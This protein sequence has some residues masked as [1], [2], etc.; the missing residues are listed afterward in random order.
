MKRLIL[1]I[2]TLSVFSI[3]IYSQSDY[4]S[5][6]KYAYRA[7]NYLMD[8][9]YDSAAVEYKKAFEQ[10]DYIFVKDLINTTYLSLILKNDSMFVASLTKAFCEGLEITDPMIVK[11]KKIQKLNKSLGN[12][13]EAKYDSCRNVYNSTYNIKIRK[14]LLE[15]DKI[16]RKA[17]RGKWYHSKEKDLANSEVVSKKLREELLII[18]NKYGFPGPQL[19]GYTDIFPIVTPT[20]III[21]HLF[22][23]NQLPNSILINAIYTGKYQPFAY[24]MM[25]DYHNTNY[26]LEIPDDKRMLIKAY[27]CMNLKKVDND[28]L[29]KM[30][31]NYRK[32]ILMPTVQFSKKKQYYLKHRD[33][34]FYIY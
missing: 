3:N 22:G 29:R 14:K 2:I 9:K 25:Y 17:A 30:V 31:N 28:S 5:Y 1:V 15:M 27:Y 19:I 20:G 34:Y 10:V 33:E 4:K 23:D 11:N 13:L 24:G 21:H 26:T 7:E 6:Y 12:I 8:K 16:D 32:E 18:I